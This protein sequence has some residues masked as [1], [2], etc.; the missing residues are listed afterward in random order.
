MMAVLGVG[1]DGEHVGQS[2]FFR[3]EDLFRVQALA[4]ERLVQYSGYVLHEQTRL[5]GRKSVGLSAEARGRIARVF[6]STREIP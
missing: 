4:R 6:N 3:V 5:E 1:D 2:C